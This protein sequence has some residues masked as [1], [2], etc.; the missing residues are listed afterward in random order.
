MIGT[1]NC[2]EVEELIGL[3]RRKHGSF[4]KQIL[5]VNEKVHEYRREEAVWSHFIEHLEKDETLFTEVEVYRC[6]GVR[7]LQEEDGIIKN[8]FMGHVI[9][10]DNQAFLVQSGIDE[11]SGA[12]RPIRIRKCR[13]DLSIPEIVTCIYDVGYL[14][15]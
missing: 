9:Y 15:R 1:G 2:S 6:G 11:K 14:R 10:R 5:V 13:G 4:A 3:Y 7:M 8:P 12:P